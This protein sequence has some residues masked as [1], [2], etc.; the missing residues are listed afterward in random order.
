MCG[1]TTVWR[2]AKAGFLKSILIPERIGTELKIDFVTDL[3]KSQ[4]CT[5]VMVITD[6]LSKDV[7]LFATK[8]MDAETCA[9]VFIDCYYRYL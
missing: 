6:R 2:E 8:S 7:F 4:G 1:Q 9:R 5:N 3:P